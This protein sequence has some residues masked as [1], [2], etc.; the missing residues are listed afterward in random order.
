MPRFHPALPLAAALLCLAACAPEA[1]NTQAA[2]VTGST[3]SPVQQD[4]PPPADDKAAPAVSTPQPE[5]AVQVPARFQGYWS[6][7]CSDEYD[8]SHLLIEENAIHF[9]ESGGPIRAAVARGD[10]IALVIDMSGEGEEWL[11]IR[12]FALRDNGQTIADVSDYYA[13]EKSLFVR[14]KCPNLP[15]AD[16]A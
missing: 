3:A 16:D 1:G 7:A 4:T 12:K 15:A 10:E 8:E 2:P 13:D 11:D 5:P 9:Y 14:S 6:Q